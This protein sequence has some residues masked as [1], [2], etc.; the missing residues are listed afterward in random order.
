MS[1]ILETQNLVKTF[2]GL[3]AVNRV[4]ITVKQGEIY[5]LIGPNGAGKT[6]FLNTIACTYKPD[7]VQVTFLGKHTAGASPD[8]M[9]RQ[10]M[11]RTFQISQPFPKL[12]ALENVLVSATFGAPRHAVPHPES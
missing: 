9:C 7:G 1:V 6:T 10:G 5:G 4:S 8:V 11:A 12:T 3:T 2:G